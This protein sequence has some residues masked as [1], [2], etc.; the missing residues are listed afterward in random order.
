MQEKNQNRLVFLDA[1]R[2]AAM[3]AMVQGHAIDALGDP[4][5][6]DINSMPWSLWSFIRGFTAPIFLIVS[7][8]VQVFANKI[9]DGKVLDKNIFSKRINMGII[10]CL[11]GYLLMFSAENIF[12]FIDGYK[13]TLPSFS[14]FNILQLIG[15]CLII[16][17]LIFRRISSIK[18]LLF[19][20]L[21]LTILFLSLSQL[22]IDLPKLSEYDYLAT[23]LLNGEGGSIFPMFPNASFFFFGISLGLLLKQ[24]ANDNKLE[25]IK[26]YFP[27]AGIGLILLSH[28]WID[29]SF[30][31]LNEYLLSFTRGIFPPIISRSGIVLLF[32]SLFAYLNSKFNSN[33][34]F[35][36]NLANRALWVYIVHL[37]IIFGT[38]LFKSF[39]FYYAKS[40]D[41]L[42]SIGIAALV[43][44]LSFAI[45]IRLDYYLRNKKNSKLYFRYGIFVYLLFVLLL[46]K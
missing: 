42:P 35:I 13:A 4:K 21:S 41:L 32:I 27:F 34:L 3:F 12:Y 9:D 46:R 1:L 7:G 15:T 29:Y 11:I 20:T 26:K 23:N 31:N 16:S 28:I 6:F 19:T 25:F 43:E 45:V 38:P 2:I 33:R 44:I 36:M 40:L 30:T 17:N 14:I 37:M 39:N 8:M 10:L 22:F 5:I 18:V 24:F